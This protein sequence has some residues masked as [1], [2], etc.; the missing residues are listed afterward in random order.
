MVKGR[1]LLIGAG[2]FVAMVILFICSLG[3]FEVDAL[4][5]AP[6]QPPSYQLRPD[7]ITFDMPKDTFKT[8]FLHDKH[9]D[10]LQKKNKDCSTCHMDENGRISLKF[11]RIKDVSPEELTE[12]YCDNCTKCHTEITAAGEKAGP[13]NCDEFK[14]EQPLLKSSRMPF[15]F[16]KSLHYRHYKA[17]KNACERCHHEY[18]QKNKKLVYAK[19]KESTCRYCHKKEIQEPATEKPIFMRSAFHMACVDCHL[20]TIAKNMFAGPITCRGCHDLEE[21]KK[22]D[23]LDK[24]PRIKRKQPD[25]V[26]IKTSEK[27]KPETTM[28]RV[29][30]GHKAHERYNDTCRACHHAD[31]KSCAGCHTLT[32]SEK[33]NYIKLNDAMHTLGTKQS[34]MGC[35]E[36]NLSDKACAGCHAFMEKDRKQDS[37]SCM[38]CHL[39]PPKKSTG[40]LYQSGERR[41]ARMIPEIWQAIFGGV[42]QDMKIPKKVVIK[43]LENQYEP[44]E[45][46]HLKI[47]NYLKKNIND[48]KLASYFHPEETSLCQ[49]CHHNSPGALTPPKCGSCHGKPFNEKN[50]S[51]PGLKGAYHRQCMGCHDQM[52]IEKPDKLEC[53]GCHIEKKQQTKQISPDKSAPQ[54][55]NKSIKTQ[56]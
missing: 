13:T 42:R 16:D 27:K 12:I 46:E 56:G 6:E 34:C 24:V 25:I 45:V 35:H 20:K 47:I 48:S 26:L 22:I 19:N 3:T 40:V 54:A 33:G 11:K 4:S 38:K 21:Q 29:P 9:T 49:G 23:K 36:T 7:I 17:Q 41:L 32:G 2:I 52:G 18:D 30:F 28:Y 39:A 55:K 53:A 1:S 43:A 51:M 5:K 14:E 31:L 44:V 10:A 15:G 50:L 37:T 8:V